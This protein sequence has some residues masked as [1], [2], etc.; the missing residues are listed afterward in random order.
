MSLC[1]RLDDTRAPAFHANLAAKLAPVTVPIVE[2]A[3]L[4][5]AR[6][7]ETDR[8]A[9]LVR[10]MFEYDP[11]AASDLLLR[12]EGTLHPSQIEAA[13]AGTPE[14]LLAWSHRLRTL[15]RG[16]AAETWLDL[17]H[18]RWPDHLPTM[19]NVAARAVGRA[20]WEALKEILP[21]GLVLPQEPV[22]ATLLAYRARA[23]PTKNSDHRLLICDYILN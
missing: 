10:E 21:P 17:G 1:R 7:R 9:E 5:L 14:A 15:G 19:V 6:S 11:R 8:A 20:D 18:S 12:L 23:L 16:E 2:R 13:V 22:S 4:V 3:A